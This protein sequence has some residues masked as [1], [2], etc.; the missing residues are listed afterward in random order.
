VNDAL[1]NRL[2]L[3]SLE[4]VAR[5]S[6][7]LPAMQRVH[8]GGGEPFTR[9]DMG[10]L[11][12]LIANDWGTGVICIPTN[13][14]FTDRIIEA[15]HYFGT[16]AKGNLRLHFSI[17]SPVPAEMDHFT[18][19]KGSFER[20]RRSIDAALELS[21]RYPNIT[22]VA[23]AT[24]NEFNHHIFRGLIDYLHE[25][26]G[27]E[28]FSFQLARTHGNYA[29]ALDIAHFREMN[30]YYFRR[31]NRQN[32]LLASFRQTTRE[33]SADYFEHPAFER[34]CSSG[35][36]RLVMAPNG[37]LYPC[38][39][40]GYPNLRQMA[41]WR[42]GNVRDFNFD[43]GAAIKSDR[44][45]ALYQ[46]I[47]DTNCHCDHNIDQSLSLLA[48]RPFRNKVLARAGKRLVTSQS[49]V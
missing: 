44:A 1:N 27:V 30:D 36:L 47:C 26:V 32:P 12:A 17:N 39:K 22:V 5:M 25:D 4:E 16:H 37:D 7:F 3:L 42:I 43:L 6:P 34:H 19:L 8:L 41:E 18:Q 11:A 35:K 45:R 10:Q 24:Y 40:L 28:D 46:Q 38:E 48:S 31:W 49:A 21:P 13:G 33:R 14:W 20:W 29:P 2:P 15:M 9:A 23:L